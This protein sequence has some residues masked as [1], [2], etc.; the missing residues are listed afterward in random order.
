MATGKSTISRTEHLA[1]CKQR[2][3]EYLPDDPQQAMTSI[4]SDL[5]KH[6]ETQDHCGIEMGMMHMMLPGWLENVAQVR[7]FILGFN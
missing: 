3:L 5:R 4:I 6:S 7:R 1:W 2:A